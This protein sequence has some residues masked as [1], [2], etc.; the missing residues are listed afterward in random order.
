M[1]NGWPAVFSKLSALA[2]ADPTNT[3]PIVGGGTG[4]GTGGN[5][6]GNIGSPA[7]T[8]TNTM[9]YIGAALVGVGAIWYFM[10]GKK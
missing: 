8:S 3:S 2:K 6:G 1:T 7:A 5:V 9:L 10:K 4:T